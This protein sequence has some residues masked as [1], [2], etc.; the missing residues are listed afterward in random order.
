M[1]KNGFESRVKKQQE[2]IDDKVNEAA[3]K[4][5]ERLLLG[6]V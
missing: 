2:K 4:P 3:L 1:T 6:T 5:A